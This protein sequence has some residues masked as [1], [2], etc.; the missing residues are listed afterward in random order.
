[1][2]S[3]VPPESG[4]VISAEVQAEFE[5]LCANAVEVLPEKEFLQKLARSRTTGKPLRVKYGADPSAPDIH[6][7]HSVPIWKLKQFQE[8]GH[9]IVFLIGGY[10]AC[11][12]D[13]SGKSSARPRLTREQVQEN[14][15]T[16]LDQIFK[17]LDPD[18]T[19]VVDNADWLSTMDV[20]ACISL[21]ARYT[22]SQMLERE[23]FHKR[24]ESETPIYIHE[25]IYPLL[26]GYDSVAI[27]ADIELG[28]TDQ[29]FNLLVGRELQRQMDQEPQCVMTMPLL[30][31]LD[32][33]N[34]MSKSLNN[35]IG[36]NEDARNMFGKAMS[37]PDELMEMYYSLA[38]TA[39]KSE[40]S[41]LQAGLANGSIHPRD[42]K[43]TLARRLVDLY[44]GTG[45]GAGEVEE[46]K[47]RFSDREFPVDTAEK[48][49]VVR[50][51]CPILQKLVARLLPGS[52]SREIQ[53]LA[54]QKAIK[55]FEQ[56]DTSLLTE[57]VNSGAQAFLRTELVPGI[58]HIKLGK[59]RFVIAEVE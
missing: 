52:S 59:T 31:G 35:Y 20:T 11:I 33:Q 10:T 26:Q 45:T 47:R 22:V 29:K 4:T 57:T 15:K 41:E 13:P 39:D 25:F 37:I 44:H 21:M 23:D 40:I 8:C 17:I 58:Y 36:I 14:A 51:E 1:M 12:G 53:R 32:G 50:D 30:V 18:K 46:F 55:I 56:P 7:G 27:K 3:T 19:E 28:G 38:L 54:E 24:F 16:Y 42:A 6:L 48:I 5:H 34:K 2:S 43:L 9:H 49:S